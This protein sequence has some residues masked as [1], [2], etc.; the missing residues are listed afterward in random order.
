[1][2]NMKRDS[3][4]CICTCT[5]GYLALYQIPD[6][7]QRTIVVSYDNELNMPSSG[8]C[9]NRAVSV[10][11]CPLSHSL[12]GP[13][14]PLKHDWHINA[15]VPLYGAN[16][17]RVDRRVN[18]RGHPGCCPKSTAAICRGGGVASPMCLEVNCRPAGL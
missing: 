10:Q 7:T 1:M 13:V 6:P 18:T 12:K 4:M 17:W 11:K 8:M 3:H 5:R 16:L 14:A 9:E 2:K 15:V